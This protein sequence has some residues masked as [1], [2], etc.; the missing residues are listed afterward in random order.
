MKREH[1]DPEDSHTASKLQPRIGTPEW[2]TID[3]A[4]HTL[5]PKR[6]ENEAT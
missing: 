2:S 6:L 4:G 5:R 1:S 3:P